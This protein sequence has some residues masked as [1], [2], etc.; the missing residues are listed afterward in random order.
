MVNIHLYR[1]RPKDIHLYDYK[2][3][4]VNQINYVKCYCLIISEMQP[5]QSLY[6]IGRGLFKGNQPTVCASLQLNR[7]RLVQWS[8]CQ[9]A[10][11]ELHPCVIFEY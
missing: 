6:R 8:D 7:A 1:S 9:G 11:A 3:H 10:K 2:V 4:C 5:T